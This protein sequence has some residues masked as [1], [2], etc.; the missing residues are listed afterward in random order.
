[1]SVAAKKCTSFAGM[2]ACWAPGFQSKP[3]PLGWKALSERSGAV[4]GAPSSGAAKRTLDGVDRSEMM[5]QEGKENG[6]RRWRL[7]TGTLADRLQHIVI[8]STV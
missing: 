2:A 7:N 3:F 4:K 1:M 5:A 8:L 6:R